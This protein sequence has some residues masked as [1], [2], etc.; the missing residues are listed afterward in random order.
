MKRVRRHPYR[1]ERPKVEFI[2]KNG[3]GMTFRFPVNPEE[4]TISRQKGLE[5]A[6][7]LNYGE[8]DF[9]QGN[10]I[11]EYHSLPFSARI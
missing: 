11:K 9:P 5:T 6:T 2:L 1:K 3:K 4:V 8:F 7:I 10:R